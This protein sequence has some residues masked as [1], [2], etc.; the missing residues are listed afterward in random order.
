MMRALIVDDE[1]ANLYFLRALLQGHG[2]VV[3]EAINGAEAL[4]SAR[5][6][7]PDIIIS[8]LLMPVLDGFSM[9]RQWRADHRLADIPFIVFT[10]TYISPDDERLAMAMGADDFLI[11][12]C[13]PE[14]LMA[15][16]EAVLARKRARPLPST[17]ERPLEEQALLRD[18]NQVLLHKLEQKML[19]T[20]RTH[21]EFR[22]E[23]AERRRVQEEL[24]ESE[25]RFRA[26]FEQVAVGIAH[27]SPDGH[28]LWVNECLCRLTGYSSAE[29]FG[30][31]YV[32]II[33]PDCLEQTE[34][35][36]RLLLNGDSA[37]HT[38]ET[39][40]LR[41]NGEVFWGSRVTTLV[42][43][44]N[45]TPRYF[46]SVIAD[47]TDRKRAE[48][49]LRQRDR[50]IQALTLGIVVTDPGR[51]DNPITYASQGFERLTGYSQKEV[52]GRN[53]RFLQGPGTDPE[54]VAKL[55]DA[56]AAARPVEVEFLN[57]RKDGTSF[58]NSLSLSPVVDED[59][60]RPYF[61]GI[62]TDV[63]ERRLLEAGL[64]QA[65]KLEAV[66]RLAGGVAHDF[67][68]HLTVIGG[69]SDEVLALPD[70]SPMIR[71]NVSA[72]AQAGARAAA[73]TRQLLD[74]SRQAVVQPRV[75]D[76]N[77]AGNRD[78]A[79]Q[80]DRRGCGTDPYPR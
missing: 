59:G 35:A 70:L 25:G 46:I 47:V 63:S 80:T 73:L 56:I 74:F 66:G 22:R 4:A 32:D 75:I 65:K 1:P 58:W 41:K 21:Q 60:A 18:Y 39:R 50:A 19:E 55:R 33:H 17:R 36:R 26:T 31:R 23:I 40:Y 54:Q 13:E 49:T 7:P 16:V 69:Y 29:F 5:Q 44:E 57:Y 61:V 20:E 24:R 42:R 2:Y 76:F 77:E 34:A 79:A 68:N 6:V 51:H 11:K 38:A 28:Y 67:N 71:E 45:G 37:S 30:L 12:P 48:A 14:A 62:Q 64:L 3:D 9:L 78:A 52:I 72:I 10:A 43:H 53:C 8:D 27:V 15:C